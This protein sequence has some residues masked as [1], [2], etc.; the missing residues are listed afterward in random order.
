MIQTPQT[1]VQ[2][3]LLTVLAA[4]GAVLLSLVLGARVGVLVM[5]AACAAGAVARLALPAERA[6]AVRRRAV[7]VAMMIA[8]AT[9]LTFLGLT[10]PL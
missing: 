1:S 2:V 10:T 8:F 7:D 4:V 5:A 3:A 9:A 6:F